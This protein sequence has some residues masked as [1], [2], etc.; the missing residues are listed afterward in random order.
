MKENTRLVPSIEKKAICKG[1]TLGWRND[2]VQK[3]AIDMIIE[4]NELAM[5]ILSSSSRSWDEAY[6]T[7]DRCE[8]LTNQIQNK[9]YAR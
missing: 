1:E 9:V 6:A 2:E 5:R 4:K 3:A 8:K 7:L